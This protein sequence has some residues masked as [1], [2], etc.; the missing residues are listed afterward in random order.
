MR[1][2]LR[3]VLLPVAATALIATSM[4]AM[5]QDAM[6][7]DQLLR[8]VERGRIQDNKEAREREDRFKAS[9]S[10]QQRLLV[11]AQTNK[12]NAPS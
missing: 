6:S 12:N 4:P 10:E 5:A 3:K 2:I 11:Q 7:M 9:R 1:H 8:A